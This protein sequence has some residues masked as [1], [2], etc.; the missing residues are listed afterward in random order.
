MDGDGLAKEAENRKLS[1]HEEQ[2]LE[3]KE[4]YKV[5]GQ[6]TYMRVASVLNSVVLTLGLV[7]ERK[8]ERK[9]K[10]RAGVMKETRTKNLRVTSVLN[11][12]VLTLNSIPEK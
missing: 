4:R 3:S 8:T 2:D 6:T 1:E 5:W 11:S 9:E 12:V 7:T 10:E